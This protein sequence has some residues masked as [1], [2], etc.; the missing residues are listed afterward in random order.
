MTFA[1]PTVSLIVCT[2]DRAGPLLTLLYALEHQ[3]YSSFELIIVVGPTRD[4]T[5]GILP[6]FAGR[7]RVIRC[8]AANLSRSR[9]IG[10]LEARGDIVAFID[11]DAIPS[12]RWL[13]QLVKLLGNEHLD[14]TGGVVYL[15]HPND[16]RVQHRVGIVSALA[17]QVDVRASRLDH[18]V[19]SGEARHWVVRPMGT[20]MAFR[21]RALLGIGGF[22][23]FYEW[24]FDE[25][26]VTMR[27]SLA[28]KVSHPVNEAIVYHIPASS[29]NRVAFTYSGKWWLQTKAAVYFTIKNGLAAGESHRAI[30]WR[31]FRLIHGHWLWAGQLVANKH[32]S[33]RQALIMQAQELRAGGI[34][35]TVGMMKTRALIPPHEARAAAAHVEPIQPF[36]NRGSIFAPSVDVVSG[37]RPSIS[38][39][40]EPLRICLLS[41]AYPPEQYEGVGRHTNLMARGLF[42]CGHR[43][44]VITRGQTDSII[45]Y[46]GAFVHK[47]PTRLE[48][49]PRY[50]NLP[51]LYYALNHSHAVYDRLKRLILNEGVQIVDSPVWQLDGLV[52]ALSGIL[53]VVVRLQT[54]TR[55]IASFQREQGDDARLTGDLETCLIDKAC[56]LVANSQATVQTTRT[57]YERMLDSTQYTV[58]P[59]GIVPSPDDE[60]RPYPV[61]SPPDC[62]TV[63]FVGRLE[64][65]KGILDLFDAVPRVVSRVPNVKF[66]IAGADNSRNDGFQA[67]HGIQYAGYFA[68]RYPAMRQHMTFLGAVSE[69]R[70]HELYQTCDLFVAPSLYESFGLIYLEAM[71]YAKPVIGCQV[72]GIPEVV[73]HGVTGLLVEPEAS[74]ALAEAIVSLLDMPGRLREMGL[75]GRQRLLDNFSYLQMARGFE[76]IYRS[77][78]A[79]TKKP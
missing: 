10:L 77:A 30:L 48:R 51:N 57:V 64:R 73:E 15:V 36:H 63:L 32:L 74:R 65:R 6:D 79:A 42:E 2:T 21:R 24:V 44:H 70:L 12:R 40:D 27:L 58:V 72:G 5:I 76:R 11:D 18:I 68:A 4:N 14:A 13:E 33:A 62:L 8:P 22:D 55:Q 61:H 28:G 37:Y 67:E 50:K 7:V 78:I 41:S 53:P 31:C 23:E 38:M 56:H 17:E 20:N 59:H 71:N 19:P 3:S 43:V 45:Y 75:S 66:V 60:T 39:P 16:P 46:D 1:E 9:N 47:L 25:T 35:A 29:R 26:D 49:Y 52:T 34:A 54:A 69:E